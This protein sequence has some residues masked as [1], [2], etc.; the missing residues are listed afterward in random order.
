MAQWGLGGGIVS[1]ATPAAAAVRMLARG[2][3]T[4]RGVLP[5]EG[6]VDPDVLFAELEPRGCRVEIEAAAA[7][8]GDMAS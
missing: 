4:E 3:I 6:C 7:V 5:P 1:T 2:A 8:P